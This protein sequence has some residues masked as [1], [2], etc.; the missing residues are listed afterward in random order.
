MPRPRSAM[1]KIRDV[2]RLSLA[3]GFS[4]RQVAAA[5]GVPLSTVGDYVVRATRAGVDW[6]LAQGMDDA[7]LER[8]LFGPAISPPSASRPLPDLPSIHRELRRKGVTLQL[9]WLEYKEQFPDGYQYTQFVRHYRAW[10]ARVDVVMR[11][12]HRAG[13]KLFIDFPGQTIP[14]VDAATGEVWQAE[15]FVAALGASSYT[16]AE[17]IASQQLDQF[18]GAHVHAFEFLGGCPQILV[19]DNLKAAVTKPHRYEPDL[20]RSYQEMAAHYGAV[21]IPAR[22]G[23]PRDK[24]KVESAVLVAERWI[25]AALRNRRFFSLHEANAAIAQK[26]AWLNARPFKKLPGSRLSMFTEIDRPALRP[27]PDRPYELA[28]WKTAVVNIDYHVEFDHH[29][30]SVPHQLVRQSVDVRATALVVEIFCKSRRVASHPRSALRGRHSTLREHMPAS[31]RYYLEWTPER[32]VRWASRTGPDTARL[33]EQVMASRQHP[34][35]GFRSCLGVL[36]LSRSYG[37][38]RLEAA[39][40]RALRI[41]ARSFKSVE[42][43]LRSGLDQAP[44]PEHVTDRPPAPHD[45]IRGADY[46]R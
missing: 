4:R 1:R 44:L 39:A 10:E 21:V 6:P 31:H 15:L 20:N 16:F 36:R 5:L 46:Y 18:I 40:R 19:P 43:I 2:L 25:L 13:E 11:Q 12:E 33:V 22:S 23:R 38:D 32:I 14:I 8:L 26:L 41:G 9:L 37:P 30:Y 29:Y 45:N 42:S 27:L 24:A 28:V 17:A 35:Q 34:E 3:E 7:E